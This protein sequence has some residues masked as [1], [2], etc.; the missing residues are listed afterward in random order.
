MQVRGRVVLRRPLVKS[1]CC[2]I[3]VSV[4]DVRISYLPTVAWVPWRV[5][6]RFRRLGP[7][8]CPVGLGC[9]LMPRTTWRR[10]RALAAGGRLALL[11]IRIVV[12]SN[13]SSNSKF[14]MRIIRSVY[15]LDFCLVL[16]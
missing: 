10:F 12:D 5:G 1:L 16:A 11:T 8:C 4:D 6:T 13:S 7:W 9:R 15:M 14:L 2:V 3:R